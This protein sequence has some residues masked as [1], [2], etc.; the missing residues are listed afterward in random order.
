VLIFSVGCLVCPFVLDASVRCIVRSLV[1]MVHSLTPVKNA[2][3]L[4]PRALEI[5][6]IRYSHRHYV[7]TL[8]LFNICSRLARRFEANLLA[9]ILGLRFEAVWSLG[10][11]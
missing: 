11:L 1:C 2:R 5:W 4:S 8:L 3:A 10:L 9:L 7:Y 6:L